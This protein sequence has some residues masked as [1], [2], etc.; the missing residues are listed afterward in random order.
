MKRSEINRHIQEFLDFAEAQRFFFPPWALYTPEQWSRIGPEADEIRRARLGWDVTDFGSGQF[1]RIG[2]TLFTLRNGLPGE[3]G[4]PAAKD[5]CEKIMMV[6]EQQVTP[7]HFHF[8]KMEDIIN[9]RG[10]RLAI[11]LYNST[12]D[13]QLDRAGEV[14]VQVDGVTRKFPAGSELALAPGESVTLV[15]GLYHQFRAEPGGG[16]ALVGEV[17]R[18]NDD[19]RDNRFLQPLPRFPEIEEDEPARFVLCNEYPAT[20]K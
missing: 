17:S 12:P 1:H 6:R 7:L 11:K 8:T 19:A 16:A 13:E 3:S 2:L 15:A 5:Y 18:V 4:D 14:V 20:A 10:G 9:R